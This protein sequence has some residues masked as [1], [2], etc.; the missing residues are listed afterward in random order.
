M[1]GLLPIDGGNISLQAQGDLL[2]DTGSSIDV[3]G[4]NAWLDIVNTSGRTRQNIA[5]NAGTV[6]LTAA[7]GMVLQGQFLAHAGVGQ[8]A[9]GSGWSAAGGSLNLELNAQHRGEPEG[10]VFNTTDRVI[11]V[12]AEPAT[13]L[14]SGQFNSGSIPGSLN[15]QAFI[16]ARQISQAGFD[17]LKLA[18]SVIEPEQYSDTPIVPERGEI[19]FNGDINL[20][21]KQ[22]LELDAPLISH[23]WNHS[24][25]SGQVLLTANTF[26]SG[27][28]WNRSAHGNLHDPLEA[29]KNGR[30]AVLSVTAN[31]IDLRGSSEISGFAKTQLNSKGDIRLIGVNPGGETDLA[32]SLT[33]TGE[34]ALNAGEIYPATL[35]Q[36]SLAVY[37][38]LS[39]DGRISILPANS[40]PSTPLSAA[41][42]LS[43]SAPN[44]F[45]QGNLL[46]PFGIINLTAG[47]SLALA[48][49]SHTSVSVDKGTLIPFG[50]TQGNLD[51]IYPLGLYNNI[52]SGTPQKA[53]TLSGPNIDLQPGAEINLNG[54]GDLSA[55]EFIA[56]PGGS[57]DN[58]DPGSTGYQQNYAIVPG[59]QSGFAPYDPLEFSSSGLSLGDSI[60]LSAYSGLSA[61]NYTLL[62]AHYALLP[63]AFLITPQ[64]GRTDM[65]ADT[66]AMR[67]DGANIV[68]GYRFSAGSNVADSRWSGFVVE[69]GNIAR[70]RSEYQETT[71]SRFF[72]TNATA[73]SIVSLPQDAGNLSLL[74]SRN[75]N[76]S[77]Q[78]NATAATGGLGGMLDISADRLAV[79]N[80]R[81]DSSADGEVKLVANELNNLNVDSILI[82]GRRNRGNDATQLNVSA[83]SIVVATGAHLQAPEILLA[84]T[85]TILLENGASVSSVGS[86]NR[87]D[88]L[89]EILND[90]GS[91]TDG[92][93]LR[94][95]SAGQASL[96]RDSSGLTR[97]T[98]TLDISEGAHLASSG[99]ILLDA[100]KD[101]RFQGDIRMNQ[102]ELTLSSSLITLGDGASSSGLQLSEATINQLHPDSLSLT[103]YS[104]LDITGIMDL[105]LKNLTIDAAAMNGYGS[106][107]QTASINATNITLQNSL[108]ASSGQNGSGLSLLKLQADTITLGAGQYALTGF[109]QVQLNAQSGLINS[110]NSTI[111]SASDISI[112]TPL[113]TAV[114]GAGTT[115]NLGTHN[116]ATFASG[117]AATSSGLGARLSVKANVIDH[118]GRIELA[119]GVVK[120][121][122]VQR[123]IIGT[124]SS[125]DTSGRD[126]SLA[127]S[128]IYS[129]G[130]AIS[131]IAG[132]GDLDIRKGAT[133]NLSGH[134]QGG[135][136]GSLSLSAAHGTVT[137]DGHIS[138][139]GYAGYDGGS[140]SLDTL[141]PSYARFSILNGLL[142]S[143]GF[144]GDLSIRQ[145]LGDFVIATNDQVKAGN[146][147]L[148]ADTGLLNVSGGLDVSGNQAG[149]IKLAAGDEVR[150]ERGARLS[151]V[152]HAN[153]KA[154]GKVSLTSMD[155]DGDG[156]QGVFVAN[157]GTIDVSGVDA[158]HGGSVEVIVNRINKD[159]AA[160]AIADH[161]IHGAAIR[162]VVAMTHY[163]D[164]PVSN[165]KIQE[166]RNDLQSYMDAA[167]RNTDLQSRLGGFT[168]Q[169]GLDIQS[170]KDLTLDLSASLKESDWVQL[171]GNIWTTTLGDIA[172]LIGSL[173][174]TSGT[175]VEPFALL[176]RPRFT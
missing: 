173:Q 30:S 146:I 54:G 149:A 95:S 79:V 122:A 93:L 139:H 172:G 134:V 104:T 65:A 47:K 32:G 48:A 89:L 60:Y 125:I 94:V 162:K 15:G 151:A 100:G 41:G 135:N 159:D 11:H 62:P 108:G 43:I 20:S 14:D 174:Q 103:S 52:Q 13:L 84:A 28:S 10:L 97:Q 106:A 167:A 121:D 29:I 75:L 81:G 12:G 168:L 153:E 70:T 141:K 157:V 83:P 24:D 42:K 117:D 92:A 59:L 64:P 23:A 1:P 132:Q 140:F 68:A 144:N 101:T 72:Q 19:R 3:S 63:G 112:N 25:V 18:S 46:A 80:Q 161:A 147:T 6:N 169:P 51:W 130:G 137:L 114:S 76:L 16:S 155:A 109:N 119:S 131:L 113:W 73:E 40:K 50:R 133:L 56:G 123:L 27:S 128:H 78:I 5:S 37:A 22:S 7:E 39:P 67:L 34:L 171:N 124:G 142:Q 99:S 26:S 86:L 98:G 105:Q 44:I 176:C 88:R 102:G 4:T 87:T 55:F 82:G 156:Q 126:I 165:A 2:M 107:G 71:A 77:A 136:V 170:S 17:R 110:G 35:S 115:L 127:S 160:V 49:G 91:S 111:T 36:F 38:Q 90:N 9:A 163:R 85:D 66:R 158:G 164:I 21:L 57:V 152:S 58:L 143:G 175:G 138:G 74:A 31:N 53:I 45:S 8:T 120:L 69:P 154:G 118:Q 145:R 61:G 166:W 129:G 148:T 33:L 116:L 96:L 150:I